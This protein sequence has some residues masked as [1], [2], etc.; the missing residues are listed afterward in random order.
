MPINVSQ[1][2]SSNRRCFGLLAVDAMNERKR[3]LF[4]DPLVHS[5]VGNSAN[6]LASTIMTLAVSPVNVDE[7]ES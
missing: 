4:T 7:N 1:R 2:N 6:L 5:V 3:K